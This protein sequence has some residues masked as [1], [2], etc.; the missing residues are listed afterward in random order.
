MGARL[1]DRVALVTGATRGVGLGIAQELG[2]AGATVVVT[3]R[4]RGGATTD[5]LPGT[6]EAAARVVTEAGGRGIGVVCDH[7][8]APDVRALMERVRAETG[9]LDLLVNN[10]WGGYEQYDATLFDLPVWEQP[11]WR[12]DKMFR[13]GVRAHYLTSRAALPLLLESDRP[14]LINIS[15]GDRGRFLGDVQYDVAKAAV[16]RL[17]FALARRHRREGLVALT[18]HPGFTRTERV[19]AALEEGGAMD[20]AERQAAYARMHSPRFVGRAVVAVATASDAERSRWSGSAFR[21]GEL[22]HA[23]DFA[24]VDGRRPAPFEIPA[25]L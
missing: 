8:K 20:E 9:R 2:I 21:V 22:G 14:L 1:E 7:T 18:L 6:V 12:W 23:L 10:V 16:D 3:G 4:S 17:G 15:A 13:T 24:D 5:D 25:D 19:E 11:V